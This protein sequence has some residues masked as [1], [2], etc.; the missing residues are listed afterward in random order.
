M[1]DVCRRAHVA[2]YCWAGWDRSTPAALYLASQGFKHTYDLGGLQNMQ[3]RPSELSR[4]VAPASGTMDTVAAT[5]SASDSDTALIHAA[6]PTVVFAWMADGRSGCD[7]VVNS[8]AREDA[9]GVCDGDGDRS[10]CSAEDEDEAGCT[11]SAVPLVIL[12]LG[13]LV[14]AVSVAACV[15]KRVCCGMSA[16][17]RETSASAKEIVMAKRETPLPVAVLDIAVEKDVDLIVAKRISLD[18]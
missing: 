13:L 14:L 6:S 16:K 4:V 12:V 11:G 1:P 8:G 15:Y 5:C 18:A 2:V 17:E 10:G 7:G 9:C 3:L